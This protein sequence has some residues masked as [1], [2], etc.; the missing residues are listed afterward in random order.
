MCHMLSHAFRV[1][2]FFLLTAKRFDT[3]IDSRAP[4]PLARPCCEAA[5]FNCCRS[6]S[7][8]GRKALSPWSSRAPAGKGVAKGR[9]NWVGG[10][11]EL[12]RGQAAGAAGPVPVR[13]GARHPQHTLS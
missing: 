3:S 12:V 7:K 8:R 11:G 2:F 6:C 10:G 4:Q 9:R 13:T 1:I 5:M